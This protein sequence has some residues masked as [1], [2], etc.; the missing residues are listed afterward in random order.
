MSTSSASW[1]QVVIWRESIDRYQAPCTMQSNP[2]SQ[3]SAYPRLKAGIP[4]ELLLSPHP[5]H[6][7][8]PELWFNLCSSNDRI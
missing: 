3:F 5:Q 4:R 2:A 7:G 6:H 8:R 1:C